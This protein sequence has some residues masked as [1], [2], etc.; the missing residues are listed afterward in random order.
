MT[1]VEG[2]GTRR[3]RGPAR[4][5][6]IV[7]V[8]LLIAC[9]IAIVASAALDRPA[10]TVSAE[11]EIAADTAAIWATLIDFGAYESW[12]PF[13][14]SASRTSD[15]E[16]KLTAH[17]LIGDQEHTKEAAITIFHPE[18]KLRWRSRVL[19]PGLRDEELE[20]ILRPV[21]DGRVLA[22]LKYRSRVCSRPL[23]T[24]TAAGKGSRRW[25]RR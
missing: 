11:T 1:A 9:P 22:R 21:T 7:L 17:L 6:A 16:G 8:A 4:W 24:T 19:L 20:V 13:V 23:R 14:V 5:A 2:P 12:N 10:T 25:R 3:R 15:A 18:R